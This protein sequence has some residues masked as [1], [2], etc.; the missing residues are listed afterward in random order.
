MVTPT[1]PKPHRPRINWNKLAAPAPTP[2][3]PE[4]VTL[5]AASYSSADPVPFVTLVFDRPVAFDLIPP[6]AVQTE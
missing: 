6:E 3:K 1:P 4:H 5:I 2:P